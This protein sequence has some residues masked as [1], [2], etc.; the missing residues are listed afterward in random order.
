[1][2]QIKIT[3]HIQLLYQTFVKQ[4]FI[5]IKTICQTEIPALPDSWLQTQLL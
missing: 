4:Q 1:M 3:D 5:A 2:L